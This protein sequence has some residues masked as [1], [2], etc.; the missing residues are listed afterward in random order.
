MS[1]CLR[2]ISWFVFLTLCQSL[3]YHL[4]LAA[5]SP[6]AVTSH[7][8]LVTFKCTKTIQFGERRLHIS[9]LRIAD[10][11]LCPVSTYLRMICLVPA[12]HPCPVFLIS[13]PVG[14]VPLTKRSFV[15]TFS[16]CLVVAGISN[17]QSFRGH[18]FRRGAAFWAFSCGA[19]G[20][21]IQLYGD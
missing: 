21:L 15:S 11:L 17:A 3:L 1:F 14:L 19:L 6:V 13:G 18:S 12:H 9:L 20:E 7:G 2:F 5:I 10:S 8:L 4:I 16:S